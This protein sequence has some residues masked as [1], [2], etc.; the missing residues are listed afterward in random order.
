M[1]C[2]IL[3]FHLHLV[4]IGSM[5]VYSQVSVS[6]LRCFTHLPEDEERN[7]NGC[8]KIRPSAPIEVGQLIAEYKNRIGLNYSFQPWT[9]LRSWVLRVGMEELLLH[10]E[11]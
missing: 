3:G 4:L 11:Y 10:S 8:G 2:R 5:I 9:R 7:K 6:K 1:A